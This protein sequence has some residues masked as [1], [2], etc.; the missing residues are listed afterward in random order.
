MAGLGCFLVYTLGDY[1]WPVLIAAH[2]SD[3]VDIGDRQD[4]ENEDYESEGS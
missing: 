2:T 4:H 1:L 3:N